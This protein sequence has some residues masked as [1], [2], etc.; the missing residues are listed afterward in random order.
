MDIKFNRHHL[1]SSRLKNKHLWQN[2]K[3]IKCRKIIQPTEIELKDFKVNIKQSLNNSL[4]LENHHLQ[5][6]LHR[7]EESVQNNRSQQI[8]N[9]DIKR[10]KQMLE[11]CQ[12]IC[13]LHLVN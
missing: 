1:Q 6:V 13:N 3:I 9:M 7:E 12:V 4:N 5:K 10:V 2:P 8:L 11:I